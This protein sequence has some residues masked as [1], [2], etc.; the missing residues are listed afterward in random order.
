MRQRRFIS[1]LTWIR[2]GLTELFHARDA[3]EIVSLQLIWHCHCIANVIECLGFH[4]AENLICTKA[5]D[6]WRFVAFVFVVFGSRALATAI[7]NCPSKWNGNCPNMGIAF[8]WQ[9][10]PFCLYLASA[11]LSIGVAIA[12]RTLTNH[13]DIF[14]FRNWI[15]QS[16][17]DNLLSAI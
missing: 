2:R 7:R 9:Q 3:K 10:L 16:K 13:F 1:N 4:F 8:E 15:G 6:E 17:S 11:M 5:S 12:L 14:E